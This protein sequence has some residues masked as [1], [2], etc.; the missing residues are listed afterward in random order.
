MPSTNAAFRS[1]PLPSREAPQI[2]G[3]GRE[4]LLDE[5]HSRKTR[6]LL[7]HRHPPGAT[8]SRGLNSRCRGAFQWAEF[9]GLCWP[10]I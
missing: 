7:P 6:G 3:W 8:D 9:Q 10:F 2:R 1:R 4:S 5:L